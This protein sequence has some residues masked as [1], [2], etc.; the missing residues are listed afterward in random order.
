MP[1]PSDAKR[2][3]GKRVSLLRAGLLG[4]VCAAVATALRGLL[5]L[6]A[7]AMEPYPLVFPA[8]LIATLASGIR[9]GLV[10]LVLGLGASDFFF[11]PPRY[12]FAPENLTHGLSM[13]VTAF[14]LLVVMWLAASYRNTMLSR[15]QERH[16]AEEHLRLLLREVD[17]RANNLL[18]VVQSIV[19]L[20]KVDSL[21]G[22][23]HKR[24]L[25][26]RIHALARAHQLLAGTRWRSAELGQLVEDELRPYT[27][28]DPGRARVQGSSMPLSPAE[29]EALAMAI[30]EL[31]TNAAKYGAFSAPGGRVEITWGRGGSG[32]RH[33]R[34]QEDGGPVAVK[35]ERLGLGVRLLETSM[36]AVDGRAELFWRPEGL[37]CEF[38]LPAEG[39]QAPDR[40][41]VDAGVTDKVA[42]LG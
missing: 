17:H 10:A 3:A 28:G 7:P 21:E 35:P 4:L 11:V 25:L 34:W 18:A 30:H 14:A 36:A 32:G 24:D 19:T 29:A 39:R 2:S 41:Q 26:G 37:I 6:V 5:D 8:V 13:A 20:T 22:L 33:I 9:G 40:V 1:H 16:E 42:R 31:A 15:A 38:D 12:S 27:L 23:T